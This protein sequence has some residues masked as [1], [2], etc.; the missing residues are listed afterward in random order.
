[1][2]FGTK[3]Q[4]SARQRWSIVSGPSGTGNSFLK[5]ALSDHGFD[6]IFPEDVPV[7]SNESDED[8]SSDEPISALKRGDEANDPRARSR[9]PSD[10]ILPTDAGKISHKNPKLARARKNC[11]QKVCRY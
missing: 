8:T 9:S 3:R 6:A 2:P 4:G 11:F 10:H 5:N 1:M 7:Q